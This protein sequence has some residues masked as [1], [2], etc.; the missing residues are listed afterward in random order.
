[1]PWLISVDGV[2][3]C[4]KVDIDGNRSSLNEEADYRMIRRISERFILE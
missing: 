4:C 1:M 3:K 2:P